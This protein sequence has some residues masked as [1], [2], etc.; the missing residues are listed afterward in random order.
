MHMIIIVILSLIPV[1]IWGFMAPIAGRLGDLGSI[2]TSIGQIL[3]L[4]GMTLFSINL[5]LAGRFKFLDRY[6]NGLD[7]VY[8]N[9]SKIGAI[10]FSMLLFHPLFLVV[11]YIAISTNQAAMFFVPFNDTPIT[12]GIFSLLL[13]II[14]ISFTFYIKLKYN[15]WKLSHKFLV[16]AFFLAVFHTL[17]ISSDISRNDFLRYYILI[18]ALIAL[19]ISIRQAFL[20]RFV[21]RKLMYK[22]KNLRQLNLDILEVEMEPVFKSIRF[23]PGQFSFFSFK[24]ENVSSESHPFSISS[25]N[26]D[27]NLKITVKNLGD[28]TSKLK[29]LK[30]GDKV[31]VDG[32]YGNFSYKNVTS[33]N[34][35]WIAGGIGITPFYSMSQN[36]EKRYNVDFY[37]SVKSQEE[38]VYLNEL[39]TNAVNN[40]NF[41]FNLWNANEKGYINAQLVSNLSNGL[42][43]K[44][45]FFCGPPKLME[46]L[47][48]QFVSLGVD[49]KNI[50]YEDFSFN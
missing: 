3:G 35:I 47:K 2:T 41:K 11:K 31:L 6:F 4:V 42:N 30:Q 22:V 14:L 24:S 38:A 50:H 9:H 45:I 49:I 1:I 20:N 13:M 15:I 21:V 8:A 40:S 26:L 29:N 32:P 46:S 28:Y 19:V 33:K 25:S 7:K 48:N 37:Y 44:D 10:S 43:G 36:L 12:W 16:A 17:S 18:F 39:Q 23:T 5:I 34:Q 27:N